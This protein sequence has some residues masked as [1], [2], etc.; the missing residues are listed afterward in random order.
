MSAADVKDMRPHVREAM[1][2]RFAEIQARDHL[3][4][5]WVIRAALAKRE[6]VKDFEAGLINTAFANDDDAHKNALA[7]ITYRG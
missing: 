3:M 6:D 2:K 7:A 5:L 4:L 1:G